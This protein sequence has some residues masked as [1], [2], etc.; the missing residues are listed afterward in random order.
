M[1]IMQRYLRLYLT[2]FII[3]NDLFLA[4]FRRNA[5]NELVSKNI[6]CYLYVIEFD[7]INF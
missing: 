2:R 3:K 7:L 5:Y 4:F 6:S 1:L